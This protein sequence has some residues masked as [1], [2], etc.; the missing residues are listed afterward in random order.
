MLD[1]IIF[2]FWRTIL[3]ILY[4]TDKIFAEHSQ[5]N[6]ILKDRSLNNPIVFLSE[7]RNKVWGV[8]V[9][10]KDKKNSNSILLVHPDIAK[11]NN[12]K[13]LETGV[14]LA[15]AFYEAKHLRTFNSFLVLFWPVFITIVFLFKLDFKLSIFIFLY[16]FSLLSI[17]RVRIQSILF[18]KYLSAE[19]DLFD[20]F[21]GQL[22]QSATKL[23]KLQKMIFFWR[24]SASEKDIETIAKKGASKL[25]FMNLLAYPLVITYLLYSFCFKF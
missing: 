10:Y 9:F 18:L 20:V 6:T 14:L 11:N 1:S 15:D 5:N 2:L 8:E 13:R 12:S 3:S 19:K 17:F 16:F 4:K 24:N 22:N 23:S 7:H 21:L 25:L